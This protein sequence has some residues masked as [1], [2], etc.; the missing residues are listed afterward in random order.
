MAVRFHL[1]PLAIRSRGSIS[2][3]RRHG[4]REKKFTRKNR[5]TNSRSHAG[6]SRPR[7]TIAHSRGERHPL[8]RDNR[9]RNLSQEKF[10]GYET[11]PS[12]QRTRLA[13]S[14]TRIA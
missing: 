3:G 7:C 2:L 4:G 9:D 14:V 1:P 12:Y 8:A 6:S 5:P 11:L 10:I 13:P